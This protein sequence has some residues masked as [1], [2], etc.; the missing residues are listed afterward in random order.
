MESPTIN[1]QERARRAEALAGRLA[2]RLF[3]AHD[4][5]DCACAEREE[6]DRPC[7][8][9]NDAA[10]LDAWEQHRADLATLEGRDG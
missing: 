10:A 2:D 8:F 9:C 5:E 1:W 4:A 3:N 7:P 6:E